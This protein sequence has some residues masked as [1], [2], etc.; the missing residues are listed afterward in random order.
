MCLTFLSIFYL[1]GHCNS[2]VLVSPIKPFSG[3]TGAVANGVIG[4]VGMTDTNSPAEYAIN[5][6]LNTAGSV[7]G[8][9]FSN[10]LG[11]RMKNIFGR[12]SK[13]LSFGI[14]NLGNPARVF[15]KAG[16]NCLTNQM[17]KLRKNEE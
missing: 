14:A 13:N 11:N 2:V 9:K 8:E 16:S 4:G 3:M 10:M 6:G 12:N 1:D 5:I 15:V 7:S 17:N